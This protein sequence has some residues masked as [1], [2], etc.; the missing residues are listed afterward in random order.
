MRITAETVEQLARL[1]R[2]G[3]TDEQRGTAVLQLEKIL[4]CMDVLSSRRPGG[5]EW[6]SG[7]VLR[8]DV[9]VSGLDRAELMKNAPACDG[10]YFLVPRTVGEGGEG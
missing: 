8:E 1:A 10:Q 3:L 4:A 9:C 5:E 7:G 2:L 6:G